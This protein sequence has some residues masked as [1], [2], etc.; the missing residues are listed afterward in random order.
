MEKSF[1]QMNMERQI[2]R[3]NKLNAW[4][5]G[6]LTAMLLS[7]WGGVFVLLFVTPLANLNYTK[8]VSYIIGILSAGVIFGVL[9]LILVNFEAKSKKE[10]TR[11]CLSVNLK[12]RYEV[13]TEK[14]E[15]Y[16]TK[17]TPE[18]VTIVIFKKWNVFSVD[19]SE[20]EMEEMFEK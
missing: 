16:Y 5:Q 14:A 12:K 10:I 2:K 3:F 15:Y 9:A 7:V 8:T 1:G 13:I 17:S 11:C 20:M 6:L 4:E 19:I 18:S